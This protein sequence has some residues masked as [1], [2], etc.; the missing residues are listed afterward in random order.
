MKDKIDVSV[1]FPSAKLTKPLDGSKER[2]FARLSASPGKI[3]NLS[4]AKKKI[5]L[6]RLQRYK[7]LH[8]DQQVLLST[9]K[10]EVCDNHDTVCLFNFATALDVFE[11]EEKEEI[12]VNIRE[13]M[14]NFGEILSV[15]FG[16]LVDDPENVVACIHFLDRRCVALAANTFNGLVFGGRYVRTSTC[17]NTSKP[18]HSFA[19]VQ[20]GTSS[21]RKH[22]AVLQIDNLIDINDVNDPDETSEILHDI[23]HLCQCEDGSI[24]A[25]WIE[26]KDVS[27]CEVL[28]VPKQSEVVDEV[29][30]PWVL[31]EC[32][33]LAHAVR[34][35]LQ[36]NQQT[37][38]GIKIEACL[39]NHTSYLSNSIRSS[40]LI[41]VNEVDIRFAFRFQNYVEKSRIEGVVEQDK[42]S[43]EILKLLNKVS[44][45]VHENIDINVLFVPSPDS[46]LEL[47]DVFL[48]MPPLL[49]FVSDL[50][51]AICNSS[52][53]DINRL[54]ID[55]VKL[56]DYSHCSH[57]IISSG[58]LSYA[59]INSNSSKT[60]TVIVLKNYVTRDDVADIAS[61]DPSGL[62]RNDA[63]EAVSIKKELVS[64]MR[65][66]A[67]PDIILTNRVVI[68]DGCNAAYAHPTQSV[69]STSFTIT[70]YVGFTCIS[71]AEDTLMLLDGAMVAGKPLYCRL[72][73]PDLNEGVLS[74]D[75]NC[76]SSSK[77]VIL[78]KIEPSKDRSCNM[79]AV[80]AS[81]GP[82]NGTGRDI[83]EGRSK[84]EMPSKYVEATLAPKLPKQELH[85]Y[86]SVKKSNADLDEEIKK[87]LSALACFQKRSKENEPLKAVQKARFSCGLKQSINSVKSGRAVLV[88]VAPD[89]E[90][91]DTL[92]DKLHELI[93]LAQ[94]KQIPILFCLS[95]RKLGK[96]VL[97][98][99]RQ[100]S[101][102]VYNPDGARDHYSKITA[103]INSDKED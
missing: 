25:I 4:I 28:S 24:N 57:R 29:S 15:H 12:I 60:G 18:T 2:K 17:H 69:N 78:G 102:A 20:H 41:Y 54:N 40:N 94:G 64:L 71:T 10:D 61:S 83:N 30:L 19:T 11:D 72:R 97:Q 59:L 42:V 93:T 48:V 26:K 53:L 67:T 7:T 88:L 98:S 62:F 91:S 49:D 73:P 56:Y 103:Y 101:V 27:V 74:S 100:V 6:E 34:S 75:S 63:D 51:N 86:N 38:G 52:L 96:A 31:V 33:T 8:S 21:S 36:F 47:Y 45:S 95:R 50:F 79:V 5:L 35:C 32:N 9:C 3:K 58:K 90:S 92:D 89:M 39:Y 1:S 77:Q 85:K 37:I 68:A 14:N 43:H 65:T 80:A 22:E 84:T 99:M 82:I 66:Y 55:V 76:I 87:M 81:K 16:A 46:H 70:A 13:L 44:D 23:Q